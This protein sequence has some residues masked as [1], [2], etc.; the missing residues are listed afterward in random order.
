VVWFHIGDKLAETNQ[1]WSINWPTGAPGYQ[2]TKISKMEFDTL[3]YDTAKS[4]AWQDEAG[5][6]WGFMALRWGPDNKNSFI[7]RGHTPD[8]CFTGA[9]WKLVSEPAPVR[10]AVNGLDLPFRRYLFEVD[11]KTA[12]VF[13]ALWD[14]RS[15]GGRQ[16]TPFAYGIPRR[17]K[18]AMQGKRHQGLKKLEISVIG[19]ASPEEALGL[20]Q[21]KLG[22]MI[23]PQAEKQKLGKQKAEM[24]TSL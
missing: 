11:G 21:Q 4:V 20:L 1:A 13:L 5:N 10:V 14:E 15:P 6:R 24:T 8:L 7:G 23:V 18:A 17:L 9:G 22:E 16:E 19:P 3:R 2:E 12:Y